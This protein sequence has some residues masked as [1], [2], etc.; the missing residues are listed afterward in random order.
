MSE[1]S[2]GGTAT[3]YDARFGGTLERGIRG[4]YR[5]AI[6]ATLAEAWRLTRGF[7]RAVL[8]G[9]VVLA[10]VA[11]VFVTVI[12]AMLSRLGYELDSN[13]V[14]V[15]MI[16]MLVVAYPFLIGPMMMGVRQAVA[17]PVGPM[18]AFGYMNVAGPVIVASLAV[19]GLS[20]LGAFTL[21][22]PELPGFVGLLLTPIGVYLAF[23]YALVVP[24]IADR[25]L[26]PWRAMETSRRAITRHWFSV[27]LVLI[28]TAL[29]WVLSAF[30]YAIGVGLLLATGKPLVLALCL[31][32]PLAIGVV[33]TLP[34]AIIVV[35]ILYRDVFGVTERA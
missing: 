14:Q 22:V 3:T 25:R 13:A 2:T 1:G 21:L 7:K 17:L 6:G 4:D 16:A 26:G 24:L 9:L 8:L 19:T 30:P 15:L 11:S 35:G 27:A 18:M 28:A 29:I 32:A 5:I 20:N 10:I 34:M 23:A 33:W 12:A 31:A